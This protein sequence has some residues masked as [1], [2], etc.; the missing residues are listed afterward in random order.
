VHA[1]TNSI[2][3]RT[4]RARDKR[5]HEEVMVAAAACKHVRVAINTRVAV[6]QCLRAAAAE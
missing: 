4:R 6:T 2:A 3:K 1:H 5:M